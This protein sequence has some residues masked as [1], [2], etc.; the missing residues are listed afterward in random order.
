MKQLN[1]ITLAGWLI[2]VAAVSALF[3]AVNS[4]G[5]HAMRV[6]AEIQSVPTGITKVID[7]TGKPPKGVV[8]T[9]SSRPTVLT[10]NTDILWDNTFPGETRTGEF[11]VYL[12]DF[13]N[14]GPYT[15]VQY[16]LI[17]ATP[18]GSLN[19][20]PYLTIVRDP[21]ESDTDSITAASVDT[22]DTS[23]KWLVTLVLPDN[24]LE[25]DYWTTI[26][27]VVDSHTP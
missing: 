7:R 23:D 24:P 22:A 10:I 20:I 8:N 1:G 9:N 15:Q 17:L 16:H 26:T 2:T 11:I 6:G 14:G 25:G 12:G 21:A 18:S 5:V 4:F 13:G 19:M 3:I 27:V